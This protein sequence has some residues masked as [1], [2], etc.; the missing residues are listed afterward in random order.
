LRWR[1]LWSRP[2]VLLLDEPPGALDKKP[3]NAQLELKRLQHEVGIT[4]IV[5]HDR[6]EALVMADRM[7]ILKTAAAMWIA[8]GRLRTPADPSSPTSSA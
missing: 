4:N 8:R 6:E 2:K 1:A 5:T 7:A 3:R